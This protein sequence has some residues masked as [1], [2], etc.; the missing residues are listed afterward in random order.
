MIHLNE[1][2]ER[3]SYS[4]FN[5][6]YFNKMLTIEEMNLREKERGKKFFALFK[7]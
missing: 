5:K 4:Y 7:L 3:A 6:T 1:T 2:F